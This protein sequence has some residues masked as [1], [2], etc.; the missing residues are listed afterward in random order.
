MSE[1]VRRGAV[2]GGTVGGGD[3]NGDMFAR[4]RA[5]DERLQRVKSAELRKLDRLADLSLTR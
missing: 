3:V 2:G 4:T 1:N 5:L